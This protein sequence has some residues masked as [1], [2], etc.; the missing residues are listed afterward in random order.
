MYQKA[1]VL[2]QEVGAEPQIKQV[3]E[4]LEALR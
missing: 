2:F 1:L 3:Q 4:L